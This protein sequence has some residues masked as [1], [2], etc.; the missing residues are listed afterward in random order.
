[1]LSHQELSRT[2]SKGQFKG[3]LADTSEMSAKYHTAQHLL[4]AAM[5]K[6]IGEH[7]VQKGSNIT[8]E[9]LRFDFPSAEKLTDEQIKSVE[10]LVNN[11]IAD[12]LQVSYI[13]MPKDEALKLVPYAA[14]S[15]KYSDIVKVYSIGDPKEAFSVEICNGPHVE[16]TSVLGKFKIVKQENLGAGLK[17]IKAILD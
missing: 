2:A 6:L 17:R 1:M 3:G 11:K 10:K 13:E 7:I 16:N 9:R 12:A 14:F 4:L 8:T 5:R 15:E